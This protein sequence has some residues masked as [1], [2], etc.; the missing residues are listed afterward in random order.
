M[1][2][3]LVSAFAIIT[4][5]IVHEFG[6]A[7]VENYLKKSNRRINFNPLDYI[8]P[9]DM[10]MMITVGIGWTKPVQTSSSNFNRKTMKRDLILVYLAGP[11][12]NLLAA[13]LWQ[14]L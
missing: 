2:S 1:T 7:Y 8:G 13:I 10:L 5:V 11:A 9:I 6:H 12:F 4:T 3:L 14:Y